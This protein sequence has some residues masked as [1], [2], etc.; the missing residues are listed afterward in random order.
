[1]QRHDVNP[2]ALIFGI[3]FIGAALIWGTSDYTAPVGRGWQLPVLLV[4]VGVIGLISA[5]QGAIGRRRK[6]DAS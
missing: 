2:I 1:V 3:V 4:G 5:V 6:D